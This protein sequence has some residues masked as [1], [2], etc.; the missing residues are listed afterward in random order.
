[1]VFHKINGTGNPDPLTAHAGT[2]ATLATAYNTVGYWAYTNAA[3]GSTT[4]WALGTF[5]GNAYA[6]FV[7]SSFSGGGG[8][9]GA[10]S[11]SL[12]VKMLTFTGYAENKTN[13][14]EWATATEQNN[15]HF[16]VER[17][18]NGIDFNE[19]GKVAGAGTTNTKQNYTFT[20]DLRTI[21][22]PLE[23]QGEAYYRLRQV[24][25]DGKSAYSNVIV[26][27]RKTG[28]NTA[29]YPNPITDVIN[30]TTNNSNQPIT[31]TDIM[32]RTVYYNSSIAPTINTTD[33]VA[34]LYFVTIGD[35]VF[36]II[37][38]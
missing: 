8:G 14:L 11:A 9:A 10:S 15:S 28:N 1:M 17:S 34:G 16:V 37:K 29:V 33:F 35:D 7:T 20:D 25:F 2:P 32:G 27:T 31:I 6:E 36:K 21:S 18:T 30:I 3:A 23:G 12:P 5:N 24:D 13:V 19:I 22:S 38:Q 4:N 26:I